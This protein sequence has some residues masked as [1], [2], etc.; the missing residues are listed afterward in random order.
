MKID[1]DFIV[2]LGGALFLGVMCYGLTILVFCL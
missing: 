1:K 2:E